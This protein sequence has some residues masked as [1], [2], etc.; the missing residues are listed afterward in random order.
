MNLV[1]ARGIRMHP[2][3][4]GRDHRPGRISAVKEGGSDWKPASSA[5]TRATAACITASMRLAEGYRGVV[6]R[7]GRSSLGSAGTRPQS[8][9]LAT[10]PPAGGLVAFSACRSVHNVSERFRCWVGSP[11]ATTLRLR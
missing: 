8:G 11:P 10:G 6:E 2:E 4:K 9:E 3:A 5:F 1:T 7:S